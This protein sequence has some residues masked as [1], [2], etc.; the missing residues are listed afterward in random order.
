[1]MTLRN[2]ESV[3]G[4]DLKAMHASDDFEISYRFTLS[5]YQ[6]Y[7]ASAVYFPPFLSS[8]VC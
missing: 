4:L 8:F 1:V 2:F 3:P 7:I 5:N 6:S